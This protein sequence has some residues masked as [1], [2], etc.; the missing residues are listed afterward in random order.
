MQE[1]ITRIDDIAERSQSSFESF[2]KNNRRAY[3]HLK[4]C[5]GA[6][7]G[8][9]IRAVIAPHQQVRYIERKVQ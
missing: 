7:D 8:T 2:I 9:H 3:P 6:I 1:Q 4:N 5:I